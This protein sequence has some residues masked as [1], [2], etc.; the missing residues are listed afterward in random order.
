M[1]PPDAIKRYAAITMARAGKEM[2]YFMA[3]V[4]R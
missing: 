3:A 2:I 1:S 4:L